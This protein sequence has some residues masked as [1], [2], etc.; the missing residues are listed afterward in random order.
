MVVVVVIII[1]CSIQLLVIAC[2][3]PKI[4]KRAPICSGTS[5]HSATQAIEVKVV[6]Y[7][8]APICEWLAPFQCHIMVFDEVKAC[9]YCCFIWH[10]CVQKIEMLEFATIETLQ[11][12]EKGSDIIE[13]KVDLQ[14]H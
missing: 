11:L 3:Q 1:V 5:G 7:P 4:Q 6:L 8:W 13:R 9:L 2:G 12:E 10:R 14:S